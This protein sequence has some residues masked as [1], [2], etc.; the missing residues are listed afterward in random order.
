MV[1]EKRIKDAIQNDTLVIFVGA[2]LSKRFG[3][4]DWKKLVHDVITEINNKDYIPLIKLLESGVMKPID[5][6]EV[7]KCKHNEIHHG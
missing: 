3:L 6:L 2:G 4:P 1:E 5:V 7:I